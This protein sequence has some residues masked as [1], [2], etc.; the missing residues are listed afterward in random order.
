MKLS[1]QGGNWQ[2]RL[3]T[4]I[5]VIF[6]YA[7]Y[8]LIVSNNNIPLIVNSLSVNSLSVILSL[9]FFVSIMVVVRMSDDHGVKAL[10]A[11]VYFTRFMYL[12][13]ASSVDR[14]HQDSSLFTWS[15]DPVCSS[16]ITKSD[17]ERAAVQVCGSAN[18][19]LSLNVTV[20]G[21]TAWYWYDTN[22]TV[23]T[24]NQ[25]NQA[26]DQILASS[27]GGAMGYRTD[28]R[29]TNHPLY[30][31]FPENGNGNCFKASGDMSPPLATNEFANGQTLST[32]QQSTARRRTISEAQDF[33]SSDAKI[34]FEDSQKECR[35]EKR[36]WGYSCSAVC[37]TSVA[38]S[39]WM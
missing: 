9:V 19:A 14:H 5:V 4:K 12:V 34:T 37:L 24:L 39:S 21:C 25:C 29:R 36:I 33:P 23:P 38:T 30:V 27:I 26:Y 22:N 2:L 16:N 17:C 35:I 15:D 1:C 32:C 10:V 6:D 20:R 7:V 3:R 18:L 28:G 13:S 31:I 11:V 8:F